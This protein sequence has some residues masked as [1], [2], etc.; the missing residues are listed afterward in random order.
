MNTTIVNTCIEVLELDT[1]SYLSDCVSDA[2]VNLVD[3]LHLG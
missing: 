2:L 1:S 3:F